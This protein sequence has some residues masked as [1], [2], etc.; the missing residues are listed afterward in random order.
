M[1]GEIDDLLENQY[2]GHF[3]LHPAR[4]KR[5]T[6]SSKSQDGLIE[7]NCNFTLG[8]GSELGEGYVIQPRFATL[9]HVPKL[10]MEKV[11]DFVLAEIN[12][13]LPIFFP[14]NDLSIGVDGHSLKIYGDLKF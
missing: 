8:I 11:R 10:E 1:L 3:I 5:D 13:R 9:E 2:G 4:P 6:T 12:K 7:I 14:N